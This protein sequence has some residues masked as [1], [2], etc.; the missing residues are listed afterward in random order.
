[1]KKFNQ[2]LLAMSVA[3]SATGFASVSSAEDFL[4]E[5][6]ADA[7]VYG[8]LNL[9][10]ETVDDDNAIDDGRALTLRTR[11]GI[12]TGSVGSFSATVEFEDSRPILGVDEYSVPPTGYNVGEYGVVADPQTTELDQAF[13]QYKKDGVMAKVGRQ[14]IALDGHRFIGHVGWRQD[15]QTFDAASVTFTP[16][17]DLSIFAAYIGQRNR[18]FAEDADINSKDV[19]LNVGYN[20][21][22][23]KLTGYYYGLEVDDSGATLDTMGLS[24]SGKAGDAD[25]V[26]FL[27]AAEFATQE[28]DNGAADFE[29]DYLMLEG[30]LTVSGVTA[31][32]GYEVLGSD[33]GNYGFSTPLATLHKFNGWADKFLGTPAVGLVDTYVTLGGKVGPGK[34]TATYH[35]FD[36]DDASETLDELGTEIDVAYASKFGKGYTAAVKA[37]FYSA[38]D[39]SVDSTRL[40]VWVSK[41]F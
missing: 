13:V 4:T 6:L 29:A 14:V 34:L 30:G 21:G 9:R 41:S 38:D 27:Y 2:S 10:Y 19:L 8:D 33:D 24:F 36:A 16:S 25:G 15:R 5:M 32:L 28:S 3:L 26:T 40:W 31:K 35:M 39:F 7:K 23:G 37:A 1:M 12:N 20:T 11:L 17:E 22:A 18:I